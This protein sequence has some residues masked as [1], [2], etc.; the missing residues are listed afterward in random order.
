MFRTILI[1]L[2]SA[3]LASALEPKEI[4]LIV[5]TRLPASR[6][7][8]EHYC[9]ARG[10]PRENIVELNL[11]LDDEIPRT[12]YDTKIVAPLRAALAARKDAVKCL[13]TVHGMPLRVGAQLPTPAEKA[14]ADRL[15]A[16][17]PAVQAKA[18]APTADA[19]AKQEL[20]K[21]ET[22]LMKVEH[23]ESYAA[24]DSELM[25]LWWPDYPL[26]RW[27][28]NPLNWQMP[29][30]RRKTLPLTIMTARLDAPTPEI[31]KRMIDDAVAVEKTGLAGGLVID[32]WKRPFDPSAPGEN[33]GYGY[34]GYDE[35]F[36]ETAA[37][38]LDKLTVTLDNE[39][40][41]LPAG[42]AKDVALYAGWYSHAKF[43][44]CCQYNRG[45]VA[46]HLASSE[47]TSIWKH[48]ST[49]WCPNLLKAGVCVT[50]GPVAEPYTVGFPKP[51]EFFG[52]LAT[53]EHCVAEVY[54]RTLNF[55]SWQMTLIGDPLYNPFKVK[56]LLKPA[57]L[58][59]SPK[60]GK[61]LFR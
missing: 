6:A 34:G 24:V 46:W 41:L 11:P 38:F 36:R 32:A 27:V 59:A 26:M 10:V 23:R 2:A 4:V 35:S 58:F 1:S 16:D 14:E 47:A 25:L 52:L 37:L 54:A 17:R 31:V 49:L 33:G 12:D 48:P 61:S 9:A 22:T 18:A 20:A 53:G 44:D 56:P 30:A 45:A 19:A 51:A 7:V 13:V 55:A 39:D 50:L 43:I 29:E 57:D 40:K 8:A 3:S 5:N 60:A 28:L 21:L 15:K 42:A